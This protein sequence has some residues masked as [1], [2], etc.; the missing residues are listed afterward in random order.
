MDVISKIAVQLIN[1]KSG[2]NWHINWKFNWLIN[3]QPKPAGIPTTVCK[4]WVN[5]AAS[6]W[7]KWHPAPWYYHGRQR[8][9]WY[10][11]WTLWIAR[12]SAHMVA[13]A[14]HF[15]VFELSPRNKIQNTHRGSIN[16]NNQNVGSSDVKIDR[17]F[18]LIR[19]NFYCFKI[20]HRHWGNRQMPW[21]N[22]HRLFAPWNF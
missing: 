9:L 13:S 19:E 12:L 1:R 7:M 22:C 15:P 16:L 2:F 20:A 8:M 14:S 18:G 11:L 3:S 6:I 10:C 21:L 4:P 17:N 5:L